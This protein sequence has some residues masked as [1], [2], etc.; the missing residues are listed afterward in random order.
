MAQYVAV[1]TA[2]L[3][4]IPD[5]IPDRR[6][7]FVEPLAAALHI[8]E[9]VGPL[10]GRPTAILGDGKLG[11][12]C[13]WALS[14]AGASV[15]WIGK[16][17]EK[18]ALGGSPLRT[19]LLSEAHESRTTYDLVVDCTGSSSGLDSAIR[20]TR[21]RGTLVLKTTVAANYEIDLASIVINEIELIGSR[22]GPF[23]P[24]IQALGRQK[25]DV[26]RLI[27]AEFSLADGEVAFRAAARPGARKV[28]LWNR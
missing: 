26:E 22:C 24:A 13:C 25:F 8:C 3:H 18:L 28:L 16:H 15:T 11:L 6:A 1:P 2:N 21:P 20:L 17:P 27:E 14:D 4:A 5:R 7:V 19:M 23:E 12:L 10:G 9:Q